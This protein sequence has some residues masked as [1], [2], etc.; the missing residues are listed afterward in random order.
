MQKVHHKSTDISWYVFLVNGGAISWSSKKQELI[1]AKSKY[2]AATYSA[3]DALWLQ[4]IM[5]EIFKPIMEPIMLYLD[6]QLAIA[7]T[8][9]RLYHAWMKHIDIWYHFIRFIVQKGAIN[10]IYCPTEDMTANILTKTLPN[11]KAKHFARSLGL[12][13]TWG[14]VLEHVVTQNDGICD[15]EKNILIYIYLEWN[16]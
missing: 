11:S 1:T 10:L 6:L 8:K 9:D 3:K 12:C 2:V 13:A 4:W 5:G 15:S 14:G 7:L 16:D